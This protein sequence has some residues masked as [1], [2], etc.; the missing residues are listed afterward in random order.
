MIF[1]SPAAQCRLEEG[2]YAGHKE[3]GADQLA[4]GG[5]VIDDA[6][7]RRH[8]DQSGDGCSHH[9]QETL[10]AKERNPSCH[11]ASFALLLLCVPSIR[12][13]FCNRVFP[14]DG[15]LSQWAMSQACKY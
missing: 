7:N 14:A 5:V 11:V 3:S 4:G 13:G 2:D 9:R 1:L 12:F 8:D 15:E 10:R 6:E